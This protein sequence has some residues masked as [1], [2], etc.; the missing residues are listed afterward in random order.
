MRSWAEVYA[1]QAE[2][3]LE[4]LSAETLGAVLGKNLCLLLG[5]TG[6]WPLQTELS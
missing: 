2:M 3:L 6:L 5:Q 1:V 4:Y